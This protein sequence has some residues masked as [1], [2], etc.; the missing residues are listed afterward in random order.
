MQPDLVSGVAHLPTAG[1]GNPFLLS[2]NCQERRWDI[3]V[4][5]DSGSIWLN[6]GEAVTK[7]ISLKDSINAPLVL[8]GTGYYRVNYDTDWWREI[9]EILRTDTDKIDPMNRA[10]VTC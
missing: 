2:H 4:I 7:S 6:A 9:A 3:K 8:G 1:H 10:Q 5:F